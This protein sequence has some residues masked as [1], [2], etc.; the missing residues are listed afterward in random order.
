MNRL[1]IEDYWEHDSS[2]NDRLQIAAFNSP[3]I[4]EVLLVDRFSS[5]NFMQDNVTLSQCMNN[6]SPVTMN[7]FERKLVE[8]KLR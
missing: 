4:K 1:W 3:L 8:W 7:T 2:N 6:I 5:E